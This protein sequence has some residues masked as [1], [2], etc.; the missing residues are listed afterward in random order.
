MNL[1]LPPGARV[2]GLGCDLVEVA[3]I[4]SILER[5]G[6]RFVERVFTPEERAL[7]AGRANAE[8]FWAA[9]F[10]AKE[11]V[12]KCFT[13]G[14]GAELGWHSI[15]VSRGERGQPLVCLDEKARALL[16]GLGGDE[17]LLSLSH[18]ATMAMAVAAIV[19]RDQ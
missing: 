5:Q 1:S 15:S 4:R 16:Q 19:K 13:T 18:T 3:R 7:C 8:Q 12:S 17:V 10:A 14:I 11:A 2:V 9:R 6:E